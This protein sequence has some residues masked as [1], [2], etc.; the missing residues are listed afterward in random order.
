MKVIALVPVRNE[1]W[2]LPHALACFSAFCDHV[3][4]SDQASTDGSRALCAEFPKV[5]VIDRT[6]STDRAMAASRRWQLLDAAREYEGSNLLFSID[7]DELISPAMVRT[8]LGFSSTRLQPGTFFR[9]GYYQLWNT[10][11]TY[12]D[13]DSPYQPQ[14]KLMAFVDD[15][16]VDFERL[17]ATAM[18]HEP[19]VPEV[20]NAVTAE[21][22]GLPV[23][24]LQWLLPEYNQVKQAWY[25][26]RELIDGRQTATELNEFYAITLPSPDAHTAPVPQT[27]LE[28]ISLPDFAAVDRQPAWH[29]AEILYWFDQLGIDY[30]EPLEIWHITRLRDEFRRRIGRDPQ[31]DRSYVARWHHRAHRAARRAAGAAWRRM[32]T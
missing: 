16:C 7:A 11:A 3:I 17:P 21:E 10:P 14:L 24:H 19:R 1:A 28:G 9:C 5:T 31:P 27:W 20:E 13:D 22:P 2:I 15:R 23:L 18:L 12:R 4:V 8:W 26:C 32:F 29:M 6:P 30:F 25:R